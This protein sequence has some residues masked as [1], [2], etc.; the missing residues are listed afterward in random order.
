MKK[1]NAASVRN[2]QWSYRSK[3]LFRNLHTDLPID[4]FISIIGPNGSGKTTLLRHLLGILESHTG[5]VDL[6]GKDIRAYNQRE[7][8]RKASYVPQS[9][10]LEYDFTVSEC[11]AM[12]RYA[13]GGRLAVLTAEDQL[14]IDQSLDAMEMR[15]LAN[16][17]ATE[18]SGGEYQRMLIA[19]ALAQQAKVIFLDEPVS[20][21]DIHNQREI[22]RLLRSLVEQ[23]IA[24]VVCILHDLNAVSAYSDLVIMMR[25][26]IIVAEGNVGEVLTKERIESVYKIE[27]DIVPNES[28]GR[29]LIHPLW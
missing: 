28:S 26:G 16:R 9:S 4:S 3:V 11:V 15:H 1:P 7:M 29:P 21:L 27:V 12:G 2:L 23:K 18:L 25:S 14:L 22:L 24:T 20:H 5:N 8:A 17:L 10:R 19:R 6:F 13:H